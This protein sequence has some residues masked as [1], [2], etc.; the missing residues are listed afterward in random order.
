MISDYKISLALPAD[1]QRIAEMSRDFI[2][3]GLGWRWTPTRV[4]KSLNNVATNVVVAREG[5]A[6]A[7]FAIMKYGEREAHLLLL[8]VHTLHRRR[9]VGSAL[10]A[11]L[12]VT[13]QESGIGAICLEARKRN[14][15]ARAFYLRNGYEEAGVLQGLYE[16][17]EDGVRLT[18]DLYSQRA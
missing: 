3:V 2:E 7:G 18:K 4:R 10:L 8:A 17:R 15:A 14:T 5:R 11:W 13:V 9:G 1:V 12:E 6:L 16:G